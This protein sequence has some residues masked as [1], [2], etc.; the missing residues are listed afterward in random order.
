M[1]FIFF[2]FSYAHEFVAAKFQTNTHVII[3]LGALSYFC[4]LFSGHALRAFREK[5]SWLWCGFLAGMSVAT[6]TSFWKGGSFPIWFDYLETVFPVVLMLPALAITRSQIIKMVWAIGIGCIATVL[7]GFGDTFQAGRQGLD[8]AGSDIQDP[9]D[10]AAQL[11]LMLPALAFVTLHPRRP[12]VVKLLGIGF[13]GLALKQILSSGSRGAL[14]AIG[15]GVLYVLLTG[16]QKVRLG[17][18]IGVPAIALAAIPFVP[19]E[20]LSRLE[21]L[22]SSTAAANNGDATESS[23]ARIA[24]LQES[25]KATLQHP[26]AGVGP[27]VFMDYQ[28]KEAGNNGQRGLWHVTHNAYTQ[29]SSECGIPAFLCYVG[30]IVL[31][32]VSLRKCVKAR[33]PELAT[34]AH[35]I[36]VM[37]IAYGTCILFLSQ[38]YTVHMLALSALT[39][40]LKLRLMAD[41]TLAPEHTATLAAPAP[42]AVPA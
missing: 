36:S 34:I 21:T 15:M 5:S 24:L 27:G 11:V 38:A 41:G 17:I 25:W 20:S 22:F 16:T 26:L 23:Q 42:E 39:V 40:S 37:M 7:L 9:N 13:I 1:L 19:K 6:L 32:F 12:I 2:R 31:T 29:V 10:F 4:W 30:A 8:A 18:L 3:I 28:A 33:D 35:V 14:V